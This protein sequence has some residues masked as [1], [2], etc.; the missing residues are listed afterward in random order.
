MKHTILVAD[1]E[2]HILKLIQIPLE[3]QGH[4][5]LMAHDGDEAWAMLKKNLP[6]LIISDVMMPGKNGFEVL[7]LARADAQTRSI[8]FIFLTARATVDDKIR[9]LEMG[10]DDYLTKP[11]HIQELVARVKMVLVRVE[12]NARVSKTTNESGGIFG[13]L[14]QMPLPDLLQVMEMGWRTG[15][16]TLD[17]DSDSGKLY[18]DNGKIVNASYRNLKGEL[19]VYRM[20]KWK[21]GKFE[22]KECPIE[23]E[24]L[25][26]DSP[27]ALMMEGMRLIDETEKIRIELGLDDQVLVT[28]QEVL[29]RHEVPDVY[30]KVLMLIDGDHSVKEITRR[31]LFN[32]LELYQGFEYL[33][34]EQIVHIV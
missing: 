7:K 21:R 8:P 30:Q 22:F 12:A 31:C 14:E 2:K 24:K 10:A 18:I 27:Q 28:D 6:D 4:R 19:A 5:V 9:G 11:F 26:Y 29:A 1:D 20:L 33:I 32:E 13:N 25:I 17:G 23:V 3:G 34:T 16:I 15:V